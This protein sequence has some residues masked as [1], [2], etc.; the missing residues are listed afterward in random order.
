MGHL[1]S[2]FGDKV[3]KLEYDIRIAPGF[4]QGNPTSNWPLV[5]KNNKHNDIFIKMNR[6]KKCS[7]RDSNPSPL[8]CQTSVITNYTMRTLDIC[9]WFVININ[10]KQNE[11]LNSFSDIESS[12][13]AL[14]SFSQDTCYPKGSTRKIILPTGLC[15]LK[16]IY[17]TIH[18][19][20]ISF[21]MGIAAI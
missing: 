6:K 1:P 4:H 17:I 5:V 12:D 14:I 8:V 18:D 7:H 2:E 13:F 9:R 19:T 21:Q 15:Q 10:T 16:T 20:P 11:R 3:L